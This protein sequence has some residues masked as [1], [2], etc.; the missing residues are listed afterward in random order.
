MFFSET[1]IQRTI[2]A[3]VPFNFVAAF[4]FGF[5]RSWLGRLLEL[6]DAHVMYRGFVGFLVALFG[7]MYA[8]LASQR[9]INRPLLTFGAAGKM[10]VFVIAAALFVAGSVSLPIVAAASG[11]FAFGSLWLAWLWFGNRAST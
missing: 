7:S 6:P 9:T 1:N 2:W 8:W 10:G 11:D 4:A 5:P 3:T